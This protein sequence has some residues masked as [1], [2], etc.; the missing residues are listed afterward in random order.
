M[1]IYIFFQSPFFQWWIF[2]IQPVLF[3]YVQPLVRRC[4]RSR[5]FQKKRF[6]SMS[7]ARLKNMG[8]KSGGWLD[9]CWI[10]FFFFLLLKTQ[11]NK[12]AWNV[13]TVGFCSCHVFSLLRVAEASTLQLLVPGHRRGIDQWATNVGGEPTFSSLVCFNCI[14]LLCMIFS[15]NHEIYETHNPEICHDWHVSKLV[16]GGFVNNFFS[17]LYFGMNKKINDNHTIFFK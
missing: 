15:R 16:L 17:N 12:I 4:F 8:S 3:G 10:C 5:S 6:F 1:V 2:T 13:L 11:A 7:L 9:P 14:L